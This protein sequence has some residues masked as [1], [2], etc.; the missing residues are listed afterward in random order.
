MEEM[1]QTIREGCALSA[2]AS[3]EL[4]DTVNSAQSLRGRAARAALASGETGEAQ[5]AVRQAVRLAA[6]G[7]EDQRMVAQAA[8]SARLLQERA[9]RLRETLRIFRLN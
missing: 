2:G 9:A 8:A 7:A 5:E 6:A 1:D 3:R 4:L